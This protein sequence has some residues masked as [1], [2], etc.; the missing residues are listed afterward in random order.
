M[1]SCHVDSSVGPCRRH[2]TL[3]YGCSVLTE[4]LPSWLASCQAPSVSIRAAQLHR[5]HACQVN[6]ADEA[7]KH[8]W[9]QLVDLGLQVLWRSA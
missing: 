4:V 9:V 1:S 2:L 8:S 5:P 3:H 6:V 7:A